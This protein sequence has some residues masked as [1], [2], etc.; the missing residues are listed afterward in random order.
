MDLRYIFVKCKEICIYDLQILIAGM[1]L[2]EAAHGGEQTAHDFANV[3][4]NIRCM[5]C[6]YEGFY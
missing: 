6:T 2:E 5:S 4:V 3:F 1:K